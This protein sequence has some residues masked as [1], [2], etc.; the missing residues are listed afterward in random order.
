MARL[1]PTGVDPHDV[2]D[3]VFALFDSLG[4]TDKQLD[5]PVIY[6]SGREGFAIRVGGGVLGVVELQVR[7]RARE[8]AAQFVRLAGGGRRHGW[9]GLIR[10]W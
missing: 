10:S 6:A 2:M 3:Q 9:N 4:A 5:F 7:Q 1:E 8:V